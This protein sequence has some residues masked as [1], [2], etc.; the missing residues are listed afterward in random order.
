MNATPPRARIKYSRTPPSSRGFG[1]A[2]ARAG[3]GRNDSPA[4]AVALRVGTVA[5]GLLAAVLLV[6]SEFTTL[7]TVHL[8]AGGLSIDA[9]TTHSHDFYALIPIALLV[10]VLA[11][12]AGLLGSRL[13]LLGLAVLA[14]ATLCIAL[15]GDL[16]DTQT[17]GTVIYAGRYQSATASPS[18]GFYLE[19]LGAVLLVVVAGCGLLLAGPPRRASES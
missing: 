2:A 16:P 3:R 18:T 10:A 15:I 4:W 1:A 17:T 8:A 13:A 11:L 12:G 9:V 14:I 7:Y 5:G 6:V 19:T